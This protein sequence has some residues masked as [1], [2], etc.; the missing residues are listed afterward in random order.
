MR[1]DHGKA[2][3]IEIRLWGTGDIHLLLP[4]REEDSHSVGF[5]VVIE[6]TVA[7]RLAGALGYAAWLLG[8]IDS[9]ERITH[10]ALAAAVRGE[11]A[12]GW[13]TRSEHAASPNSGTVEGFGQEHERGTPV[14]LS[15]PHRVRAALTMDANRIVEDLV[16]LLRRRWKDPSPS[17]W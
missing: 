12:F 9:T 3:S 16:V 8:H 15:P 2:G 1:Q 7:S 17:A 6:E 11:V 13:R 10:V 5:P 4:A 14:L